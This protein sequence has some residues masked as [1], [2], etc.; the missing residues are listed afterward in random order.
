MNKSVLT[1]TLAFILFSP[2]LYALQHL[3]SVAIQGGISQ[4]QDRAVTHDSTSTQI[5][6]IHAQQQHK[7]VAFGSN[8]GASFGHTLLGEPWAL[9][10]E[11]R[12]TLS[13]FNHTRA[14][15]LSPMQNGQS[16]ELTHTTKISNLYQ[17]FISPGF[18][19]QSNAIFY[20]PLVFA[21]APAQVT[22][23][24]NITQNNILE[25]VESRKSQK[26]PAGMVG[27]GLELILNPNISMYQDFTFGYLK[28]LELNE[29]KRIHATQYNTQ[30]TAHRLLFQT[31]FGIK[32][33]TP[34]RFMA[35]S[36]RPLSGWYMGS[37]LGLL[38]ANLNA[39]LSNYSAQQNYLQSKHRTSLISPDIDVK[40][41][42]NFVL[43]NLIL[44][45]ELF[46]ALHPLKLD[47]N[48]DIVLTTSQN[49][50]GQLQNSLQTGP[51]YGVLLKPGVL[52]LNR[53][54]YIMLGAGS[55]TMKMNQDKLIHP[56]LYLTGWGMETNLAPQLNLRSE[57]Q[58]AYANRVSD[59]HIGNITKHSEKLIQQKG[60]MS[61]IYYFS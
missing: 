24:Q 18:L 22:T 19:L 23:L 27:L 32:W 58:I 46:A 41:G 56:F 5:G 2:A 34:Y 26:L 10:I 33:H 50:V 47:R 35:Q 31:A 9:S 36:N 51:T 40:I 48:P 61:L 4:V 7:S 25:G 59:V 53:A 57:Y 11:L 44:F 14:L 28:R 37:G 12:A 8:V 21:I 55:T 3:T 29:S 20:T 15:N 13:E 1:T 60:A 38:Q 6:A 17:I 30:N 45:A 52:F 49:D 42:K 39:S 43:E 16:Y 54:L